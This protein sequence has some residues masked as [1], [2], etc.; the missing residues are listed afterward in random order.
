M[1][2]VKGMKFPLD[3]KYYTKDG[4]HI[5]LKSEDDIVKVG[6]DAFAVEM[7]GL[8]TYLTVTGKQTEGGEAVG[9]F[10]SAKFVSRF[11]SPISGQIVD[12]NEEVIKNPRKINDDP[13]N[14]WIFAIKP[15]PVEYN[16]KYILD[17]EE[18]IKKWISEELKRV[19]EDE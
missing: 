7:A 10:E 19:E 9:S 4:A 6:M 3:R 13:Y 2:E 16:K 15:N 14:S 11:Y 5:W 8:L 17:K 1:L 18:D 12:I